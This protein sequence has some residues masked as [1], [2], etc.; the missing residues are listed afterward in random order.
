M[1]IR[2]GRW[3]KRG[4]VTAAIAASSILTWS[5]TEDYFEV[6]KNLDIY[7]TLFRELNL[8]YVDET[9]PG[10]LTRTGIDAMLASLDPYTQYIPESDIEDYRMKYVSSEYGGIGAQVFVK[11]GK[12]IISDVYE[13]FPAQKA[14]LQAGDIILE[15]NGK[16][17]KGKQLEHVSDLLKGQANTAVKVIVQREGTAKPIEANM[18]REEIKLGDVP[19]YGLINDSTGYIKLNQFLRSS[20]DEVRKAFTELKEKNHIKYLVFDLRGNGGGILQESVA[21][22]NLFI[23]QGKEVVTQKGRIKETNA[24]YKTMMPALDPNI[25]VAVLV[26]KGS[27]SASEIMAGAIQDLDRGVIIGKPSFGKGLVQQTKMLS[28]NAQLKLTVAKYYTPSGRCVQK[29]NYAHRNED[30]TVEQVPDSLITEYKTAHGRSVFDGSGI[31]PDIRTGDKTYSSIAI[32][33]ASK[34]LF[35][36]YATKYKIAHPTIPAARSFELTDAD[37]NDFIAF[38][39]NKDYDYTT[40]SEK[41]LKDMKEATE[42]DKSFESIKTEYEAMQSKIKHD[43]QGD[44]IKF[45]DELKDLLEDEIVSR[46]YYERGRI[47]SSFNEDEDIK[48]ALN[49]FSKRSTYDSILTGIGKYKVIGEPKGAAYAK[50]KAKEK[51]SDTN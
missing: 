44:L 6:S 9:N 46:Y 43:K 5:F 26:D 51:D 4:L 45:K 41:L 2:T 27:A 42:K 30:G 24:N 36:D 25:P 39:S 49:V 37:Y 48:A 14:G 7:A 35:F 15:V 28:Y 1:K 31:Y 8:Y 38:L 29:L 11:D 18:Q 40:K 20:A 19:Y 34:N 16:E 17:A 50:N 32:S 13:G 12:A 33:L 21:I 23:E 22:L 3:M 10:E 47:E